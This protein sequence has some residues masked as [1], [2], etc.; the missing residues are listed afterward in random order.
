MVAE[1]DD[2][3]DLRVVQVVDTLEVDSDDRVFLTLSRRPVCYLRNRA[4]AFNICRILRCLLTIIARI[5]RT[6]MLTRWYQT[7]CGG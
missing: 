2:R 3:S 5:M 7:E 1:H 6:V 4:R